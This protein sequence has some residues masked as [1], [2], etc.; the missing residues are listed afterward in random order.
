MNKSSISNELFSEI[1]KFI[2][3]QRQSM[4]KV[5]LYFNVAGLLRKVYRGIAALLRK[6]DVS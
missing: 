1:I 4:G 2:F 5:K 3:K 6:F